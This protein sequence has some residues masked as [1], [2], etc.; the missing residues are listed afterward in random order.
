MR[1]GDGQ[2]II[3][4]LRAFPEKRSTETYPESFARKET[5]RPYVASH[6]KTLKTRFSEEKWYFMLH[7]AAL[8]YAF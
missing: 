6:R 7:F 3:W 2:D 4:I 5:E 8:A 1:Q